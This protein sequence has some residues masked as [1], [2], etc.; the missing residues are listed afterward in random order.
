MAAAALAPSLGQAREGASAT[1]SSLIL[2][3]KL[4][5][6][7]PHVERGTSVILN[8]SIYGIN[9]LRHKWQLKPMQLAFDLFKN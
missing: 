3:S 5:V 2:E 8:M 4:R 7:F 9:Y 6:F 1:A